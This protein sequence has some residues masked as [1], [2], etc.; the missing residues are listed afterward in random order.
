MA[1]QPPFE[2]VKQKIE[3]VCEYFAAAKKK[4]LHGQVPHYNF[5]FVALLVL[6]F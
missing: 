3:I 6:Y 1:S 4:S 5:Y 2:E